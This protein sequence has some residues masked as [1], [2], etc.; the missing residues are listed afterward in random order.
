MQQA[1]REIFNAGLQAVDPCRALLGAL[2]LHGDELRIAA[3]RF[4]LRS[5]NRIIV[6]GAGKATARMALA[7]ES[8][9]YQR[10]EQGMVI[11]KTGHSVPLSIIETVE[12]GHPVPDAAGVAATARILELLRADDE[13]TLCICLLSGGASALLVAPAGHLTLQDKQATTRLLL[14]AGAAIHEMNTLRKHLSAVKGGRL[15]QAAHPA[16]VLTLIL[17]DVIG[18]SLEVIASGPTVADA[19]SF[20]DAWRVIEK[21]GL[22]QKIP[23]RVRAHLQ[24]GI[25]GEISET[26]K[27]GDACLHSTHNHIIANLELALRAAQ[28]QAT[29]LDWNTRIV[30]QALHGEA[31]KAARYLAQV[32]RDEWA[33]MPE[34]G[35]CCLLSGGETT[36]T[37]R[38]KG[39]GGRNQ[40]FALA[41]ALAIAGMQGVTL[42]SAGT[43]GSDGDNDAAGALVD[44]ATVSLAR[45]VGLDAQR[46]LDDNDSYHFFQQLDDK[47]RAGSHFKTGATG[48]NVMDMQI[49]LLHKHCFVIP[50]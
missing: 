28:A 8:L 7:I 2:R 34:G 29:R 33:A 50:A 19:T 5:F 38:G 35:R 14:K 1:A 42:L 27:V 10:I 23:P 12:A 30:T 36:V 31:R 21:F 6:V 47:T 18:D 11:V 46:Y 37:V 43:D 20:A 9:L 48:T 39:R 40:E 26:V 24:Q 44:G 41:F 49:I 16:S 25:A 32:V 45:S 17:S 3:T 13:K 15:A 22:A 4:D